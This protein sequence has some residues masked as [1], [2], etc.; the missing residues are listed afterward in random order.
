[1]IDER[2][3][4]VRTRLDVTAVAAED[5]RS[6]PAPVED[7]DRLLPASGVEAGQG[8]CQG[9]R[10]QPA[11]AGTSPVLTMLEDQ[12]PN[13]GFAASTLLTMKV[14]RVEEGTR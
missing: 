14:A 9:A 8:R 7:E 6:G 1:V 10:Q 2:S 13:N 5:D 3:L 4:A 12:T 11:L